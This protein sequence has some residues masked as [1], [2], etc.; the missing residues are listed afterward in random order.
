MRSPMDTRPT[1][2][3][4]AG[5]RVDAEGAKA[6]RHR[7][8]ARAELHVRESGGHWIGAP[9]F[10]VLV[11]LAAQLVFSSE[12]IASHRLTNSD[13]CSAE[14]AFTSPVLAISALSRFAVAR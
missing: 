5:R 12:I 9:L 14:S 1:V 13:H 4:F 10:Y 3:A 7:R 6:A 2:V 8:L 11:H